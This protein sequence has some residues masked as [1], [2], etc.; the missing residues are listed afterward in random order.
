MDD[1]P[2]GGGDLSFEAD[3]WPI[4]N[5]QCGP[6]HVSLA[7]G[8]QNIGSDDLTEALDDS[9]SFEAAVIREIEAGEM[10]PSCSGAP[11]GGAGCVSADELESIEAWYEAGAAP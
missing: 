2:A 11:P 4:F 1:A 5:G 10:P 3:I 8:N 6:C 7:F 9:K